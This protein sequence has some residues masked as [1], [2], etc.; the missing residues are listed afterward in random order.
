MLYRLL[1]FIGDQISIA[2][3]IASYDKEAAQF[4]NRSDDPAPP[5]GIINVVH[6]I[7]GLEDLD[8]K[9]AKFLA[10]SWQMY[11]EME[12]WDCLKEMKEKGSEITEEEW[13]F[14]EACLV[15]AAGNIL[16]SLVMKRYGGEGAKIG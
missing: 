12:I 2:N 10:Y 13:R 8:A 1:R 4:S 9:G 14:V 6:V 15:C 5:P 3:D 16:T 7:M 11:M